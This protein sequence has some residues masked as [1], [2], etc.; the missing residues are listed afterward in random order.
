MSDADTP[1]RRQHA[2]RDISVVVGVL[3][4]IAAVIFSAI[5][6]RDSARSNEQSSR[7]LELQRRSTDFQTLMSVSSTLQQSITEVE[8]S[9]LGDGDD[10]P[11][12]GPMLAAMRRNEPIAFALNRGLVVIPGAE[13][14]WGN[15]LYCNWKY[16]QTSPY[17][18][19]FPRHV[20]EPFGTSR[21][22]SAGAAQRGMPLAH[23]R[24]QLAPNT[25]NQGSRCR[26]ASEGQRSTRGRSCCSRKAALLPPACRSTS[27][28]RKRTP[29]GVW[30]ERKR[31]DSGAHWTG[32][33]GRG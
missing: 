8:R 20:P 11:P 31:R 25:K 3:S 5:Q 22:T 19:R 16:I 26:E 28:R 10:P 7:A 14:L 27:D 30:A 32:S 17:R 9:I 6:V 24:P 13:R 1:N 21:S 29:G 23:A 12:I 15:L 18:A 2:A 4:L 33:T